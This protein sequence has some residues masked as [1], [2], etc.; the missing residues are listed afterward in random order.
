VCPHSWHGSDGLPVGDEESQRPSDDLT[1]DA[2]SATLPSPGS[3]MK[4]AVMAGAAG[5]PDPLQA[6]AV[7]GGFYVS[8]DQQPRYNNGTICRDTG[9]GAS[10]EH[11]GVTI[12][13]HLRAVVFAATIARSV[14]ESG[15]LGAK[16]SGIGDEAFVAT[17][18]DSSIVQVPSD[19]GR[20][21]VAAQAA[22]ALASAEALKALDQVALSYNS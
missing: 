14:R 16:V 10:D 15:H 12:D 1:D 13:A 18:G 20:T 3:T 8:L 19:E 7:I 9:G 6:D 5:C 21:L 11:P 4:V 22:R 17:V 2:P